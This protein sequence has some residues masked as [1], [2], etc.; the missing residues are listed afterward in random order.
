MTM[1]LEVA[2]VT[3]PFTMHQEQA[4][5]LQ[6]SSCSTQVHYDL[7]LLNGSNCNDDNTAM[8]S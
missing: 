3:P 4:K 5:L 7:H 8:V 2:V 1:A 6:P